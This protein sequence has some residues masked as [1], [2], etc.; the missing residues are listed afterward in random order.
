M[1][2]NITRRDAIKLGAVATTIGT[3]AACAAPAV[4]IADEA[5]PEFGIPSTE[6]FDDPAFTL[7]APGPIAFEADPIPDDQI[8]R[9]EE[10]EV[11]IL[12]CGVAGICAAAS[13]AENGLAP[14]VLEKG[15]SFAFRGGEICAW[16]DRAHVEAGLTATTPNELVKALADL[17]EWRGDYGLFKKW[18]VNCNEAVDWF[19]DAVSEAAGPMYVSWKN[20]NADMVNTRWYGTAVQWPNGWNAALQAMIDKA[21]ADGATFIYNS[22][23]VQLV[24]EDGA[25]AGAIA[26]TEE[27]Y[28]KY[29]AGNVILATGSYDRNPERMK[30]YMRPRDM[31][32]SIWMNFTATDTGDGHEMGLA[33]GAVEDEYPHTLM[34]ASTRHIGL[35]RVNSCGQRFTPEYL[36]AT[37]L[38]NAIQNQLGGYC[39]IIADANGLTAL[40]NTAGDYSMGGPEA[41]WATIQQMGVSADTLEGLAEQMGVPADAF[42]KTINR[43]NELCEKGVDDDFDCPAFCLNAIAEP[44]FYAYRE[45]VIMLLSVSGLRVTT[46]FEVISK[47]TH[48]PIPGL[49]AIGNVMGGMFIGSYAHNVSGVSHSRCITFGKM[50]GEYLAAKK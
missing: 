42:V 24:T 13:C 48:S 2:K 46:D 49:Y 7:P 36:S 20:G 1:S 22:P 31:A 23:A 16:G 25:V 6:I 41:Q 21:T 40:E 47:E 14:V 43:Y 29:K 5:A 32:A 33:V 18:S 3:V 8:V 12:G 15:E 37:L 45:N 9:E 39:W 34:T 26:K 28:I 44:P 35:L 38:L 19:D 27:G 17:S 11:L 50:L 10:A 30:K 4:S